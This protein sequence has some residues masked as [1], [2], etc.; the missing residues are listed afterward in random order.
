MIIQNNLITL[1]DKRRILLV[2]NEND[3]C[4]ALKIVLEQSNFVVN[5]YSNPVIAL[6]EFKSNFYDLLVFDI[7][8]SPMNGFELYGEIKKKGYQAKNLLHNSR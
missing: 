2:D 1:N 5:Y 7:K 4:L 3:I 6:D 8:M